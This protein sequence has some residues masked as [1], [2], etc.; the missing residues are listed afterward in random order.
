M[1]AAQL[2]HMHTPKMYHEISILVHDEEHIPVSGLHVASIQL[3]DLVSEILDL[4]PQFQL[5]FQ[6]PLITP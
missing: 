3:V 5:S 1:D 2:L 4:R 6:T